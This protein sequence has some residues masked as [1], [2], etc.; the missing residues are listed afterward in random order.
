ML[1]N[2]AAQARFTFPDTASGRCGS[3]RTV[4]WIQDADVGPRDIAGIAGDQDQIVNQ[5]RCSQQPVDAIQRRDEGRRR[6]G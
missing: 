6:N 5:R 4:E 1:G 2:W 3:D